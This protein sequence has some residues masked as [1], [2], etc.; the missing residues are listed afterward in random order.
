[1]LRPIRARQPGSERVFQLAVRALN[2][3][4]GL[5]ME[6]GGGDVLYL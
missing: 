6:S 1:M 2:H 4:I 3:A 5:W